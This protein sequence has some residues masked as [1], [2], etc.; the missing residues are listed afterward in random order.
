M[1]YLRF[2][3]RHDSSV[4]RAT[5]GVD[6]MCPVLSG[7]MR[8]KRIENNG[9]E[10]RKIMEGD[11]TLVI[12]CQACGFPGISNTSRPHPWRNLLPPSP[13]PGD[14]VVSDTNTVCRRLGALCT[15]RMTHYSIWWC[16]RWLKSVWHKS[17][18][19]DMTSDH[20]FVVWNR[21]LHISNAL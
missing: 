15:W 21:V 18:K 17:I 13:G 8:Y 16:Q 2:S 1:K 7:K 9:D 5:N 6:E 10:V 4:S 12:T 14:N 11:D 20:H 19:S 3:T